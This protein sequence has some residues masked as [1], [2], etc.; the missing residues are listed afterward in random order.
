MMA[1]TVT[2]TVK[3]IGHV[4]AA[5]VAQLYLHIPGGPSR[6]LRG[7]Q[8][9]LLQPGDKELVTFNLTRRDLSSWNVDAQQWMLQDGPYEVFVGKSVLDQQLYGRFK[10]SS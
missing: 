4:S 5:E 6:V 2:C 7:F 8:K 10:V 3:N 9:K 1:A